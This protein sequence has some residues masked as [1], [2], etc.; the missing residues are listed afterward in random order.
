MHKIV[1][2]YFTLIQM[3]AVICLVTMVVLVFGNVVL[4]YGFNESILIS[5]EVSRWAFVWL[6]FLGAVVVLRERGHMGVDMAIRLLPSRGERGCLIM[7]QLLM[8]F[9]SGL[10]VWGSWKQMQIN[11]NIPSPVSGWSMGMFYASGAFFGVS[12]SVIH[13]YEAVRLASGGEIFRPDESLEQ[14]H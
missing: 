12:A 7:S 3:L 14:H 11:W 8:L 1:N 9:C 10:L 5:E 13:V 2:G 4:R 6:T